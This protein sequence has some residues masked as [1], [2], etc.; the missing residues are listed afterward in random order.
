M[1]GF[2]SRL[3]GTLRGL[4][5]LA[6]DSKRLDENTLD[7]LR[8]LQ[9]RLHWEEELLAG[10]EPPEGAR[11]AHQELGSALVDAR[12]ATGEVVAAIESDDRETIARLLPEWRGTLFSVRLA[13]MR[14]PTHPVNPAV[15]PFEPPARAAVATALAVSGVAAFTA[16]AVLLLWPIWA[17][18]L[19]LVAA[20]ILAYRP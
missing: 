8:A 2:C 15:R 4:E 3:A 5:V 9:N 7:G 20:G 1:A 6:A 16:G 10:V 14:L 13:R 19:T 18:G 11:G 12:D 17:I